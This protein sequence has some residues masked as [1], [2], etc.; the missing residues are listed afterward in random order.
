MLISQRHLLHLAKELDR[1][2]EAADY[3]RQIQRTLECEQLQG[4]S[5]KT[6]F[7]GYQEKMKTAKEIATLLAAF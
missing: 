6:L 3:E 5:D 1:K 7:K 4:I 2:K